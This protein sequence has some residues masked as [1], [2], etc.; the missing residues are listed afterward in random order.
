MSGMY[1]GAEYFAVGVLLMRVT[2]NC[3]TAVTSIIHRVA[4]IVFDLC[5]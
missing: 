1:V 2:L 4:T 3:L 5:G